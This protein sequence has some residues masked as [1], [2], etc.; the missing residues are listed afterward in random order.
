MHSF[1]MHPFPEFTLID[2][3]KRDYTSPCNKANLP[4]A[5]VRGSSSY[6]PGNEAPTTT[7]MDMGILPP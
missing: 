7:S 6:E 1:L 5:Q 2:L 3:H 4:R